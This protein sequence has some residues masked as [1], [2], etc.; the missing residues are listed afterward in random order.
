MN[1]SAK[2]VVRMLAMVPFLQEN[3]GIPLV[4]LAREFGIKPAKAQRELEMLMMTGWGQYHGQMIDFDMTALEVDGMVYIRDAEFMARPLRVS[5]SEAAAL[6]IALRSLRQGATDEQTAIIDSAMLKLSAAAG[7]EV[8]DSIQVRPPLGVDEAIQATVTQALANGR[9][10]ALA[11]STESRDEL[12]DR[13]VEPHRIFDHDG[14]RYLTA[15]CHLAEA[16]RSFRLDR[17]RSATML[18]Q[19][20]SAVAEHGGRGTIFTPGPDGASALVELAAGNDWLLDEYETQKLATAADGS[21]QARLFGS[22]F[23]WLS[24][25]VLRAGGRM[26]VIGPAELADLVSQSAAAALAAYDGNIPD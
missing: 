25:V 10:L 12:T 21:V 2:Q 6:L 23:D 19:A 20:V 1:P 7:T 15:W 16:E 8:D 18:D 4:E 9:Q 17:I 5:R 13:V 26:K 11:Y 14:R 3:Q 24:R 22:D